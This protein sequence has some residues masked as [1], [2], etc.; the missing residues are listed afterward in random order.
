MYSEW[1]KT[2]ISNLYN[3]VDLDFELKKL[4]QEI[5]EHNN[6][7][8]TYKKNI[9]EKEDTIKITEKERDKLIGQQHTNIDPKIVNLDPN[10]LVREIE[11]LNKE[12]GRYTQ[13]N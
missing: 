13:E 10:E 6:T 7:I 3:I 1:S 5:V 8:K 11:R 4:E 12:L 9:K 2:L